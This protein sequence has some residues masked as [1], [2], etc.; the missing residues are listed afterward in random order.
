A[1]QGG[2]EAQTAAPSIEGQE[3]T[4]DPAISPDRSLEEAQVLAVDPARTITEQEPGEREMQTAEPLPDGPTAS[5]DQ[6]S[7]V[8]EAEVVDPARSVREQR[9]GEQ[10]VQTGQPLSEG[11]A[12]SPDQSSAVPEGEAVGPARSVR[13]QQPDEQSEQTTTPLNSEQSEAQDR[14]INPGPP[15][16]GSEVRP[17]MESG[18]TMDPQEQSLVSKENKEASTDKTE[19]SIEDIQRQF[20]ASPNNLERLRHPDLR[21]LV[22][23]QPT[24]LAIQNKHDSNTTIS[25]KPTTMVPRDN[26]RSKLRPT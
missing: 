17:A 1:Y 22:V 15:L 4:H 26:N 5:P 13:E 25:L 7:A 11:P 14:A 19:V 24:A 3:E 10:E 18:P 9:P 16:P 8:P 6:S 21:A 12:T 23:V 20:D 2:G